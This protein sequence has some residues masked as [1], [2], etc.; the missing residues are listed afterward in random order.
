MSA[1]RRASSGF[2]TLLVIAAIVLGI[3]YYLGYLSPEEEGLPDTNKTIFFEGTYQR[4]NV[5]YKAKAAFNNDKTMSLST[6][7]NSNAWY[8]SWEIALANDEMIKVTAKMSTGNEIVV[9][10]KNHEAS[11]SSSGHHM[12]NGRWY[13]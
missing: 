13:Q 3:L 8:G 12:I 6:T 4:D 7:D 2:F 1:P 11:I 5:S 9:F 10:Y